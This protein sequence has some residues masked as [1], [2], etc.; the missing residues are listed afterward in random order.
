MRVC[1]FIYDTDKRLPADDSAAAKLMGLHTN[2]YRKVRDQLAALGKLVMRAGHWTVP[3]AD[4]ELAAA[5][6]SSRSQGRQTD[7]DTGRATREDTLNETPRETH[8]VFSENAN[9]INGP[10]KS[11]YPI[12]NSKGNSTVRSEY[13]PA[14]GPDEISGLNGS[15][16]EIVEGIAKLLN[17][18][19]P[20]YAS[21]RRMITSNVSIY[22]AH[23]I[24]DGYAE[25][26]ADIADNKVRV[27]S[28][29]ALLGYFKTAS[30]RPIGHAKKRQVSDFSSQRIERGREFLDLLNEGAAA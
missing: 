20:D 25:L 10:L 12:A 24:R 2:A 8:Q 26:M 13:R 4:K 15:T 16:G 9:E 18:M 5:T 22:G 27:P 30:E 21:A 11:Q 17:S 6:N 3:R 19:A 14:D 28:Y 29:K 23:A 7:Q 1:A